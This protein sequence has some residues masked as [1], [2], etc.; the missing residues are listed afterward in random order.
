MPQ[1]NRNRQLV[2]VTSAVHTEDLHSS[3]EKGLQGGFK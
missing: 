3:L 2:K 1:Q